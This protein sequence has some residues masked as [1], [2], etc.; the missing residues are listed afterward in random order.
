MGRLLVIVSSSVGAVSCWIILDIYGLV[1]FSRDCDMEHLEELSAVVP[2]ID[3]GEC[4][5]FC[6]I[7]LVCHF[8]D[9]LFFCV[10]V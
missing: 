7:N 3:L 1:L 2:G 10:S 8:A 4:V 9:K 6:I 5:A